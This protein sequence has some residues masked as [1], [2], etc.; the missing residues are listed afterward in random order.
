MEVAGQPK[1]GVTRVSNVIVELDQEP[2]TFAMQ[3]REKILTFWNEQKSRQPHFYNGQ[4][5]VMT[6]WSVRDG[7]TS[8][9]IFIGKLVRTDFASYLYWKH[10]D[11][12]LRSGVDFSGG[13]ALVCR[14]SALLMVLSGAHTIAP[15]TL[16]FPSGFVDVSDFD[17]DKLNFNR[18][19]EREVVEELAITKQQLGD[20][21]QYLVSA[22]DRVVQVLSIFKIE[23][24]GEEFTESWRR[25]SSSLRS[26]ISDVVAIHHTDD[27]AGLPVQAHVK[28]AAAHLLSASLEKHL[29]CEW[30][31]H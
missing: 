25:R 11:T 6:S 12:N 10:S 22:A 15:G 17:D 5:H 2:W 28:A 27:L 14:N 1:C 3:N 18:H 31:S 26:E 20:P 29:G 13:A 30:P 19:V 8:S 23:T 21:K 7:E 16:E 4:V 9:A 24:E